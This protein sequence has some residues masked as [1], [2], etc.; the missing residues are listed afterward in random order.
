MNKLHVIQRVTT[1]FLI[2]SILILMI[3]P[4]QA[5]SKPDLLFSEGWEHWSISRTCENGVASYEMTCP[6]INATIDLLQ[7]NTLEIMAYCMAKNPEMPSRINIIFPYENK[8][9]VEVTGLASVAFSATTG[10]RALT[11][12]FLNLA[13]VKY[14]S[15]ST[16]SVV[17]V[18]DVNNPNTASIYAPEVSFGAEPLAIAR[19]IAKDIQAETKIT[20]E[21]IVLLNDYIIKH[22]E[23]NHAHLE[24]GGRAY[25]SLGALV[26]GKA[27]CSGYVNVVSDVCYL[28]NIP[29]YQM[30]DSKNNHAWNVVKIDGEWLMLDTTFNDTGLKAKGYYLADDFNDESHFYT[31]SQRPMLEKHVDALRRAEDAADKFR[32]LGLI[33]GDGNSFALA[34]ALTYEALAVILSRLDG[35]EKYIVGNAARLT[36]IGATSGCAAWA[37]PYVGYCVEKQYYGPRFISGAGMSMTVTYTQEILCDYF[38]VALP[39][40]LDNVK[41]VIYSGEWTDNGAIFLRG[42]FFEMLGR[43]I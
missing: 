2:L 13:R 3:I 39:G 6:D 10:L 30:T 33:Q 19:Q 43:C 41:A 37:A 20:R 29:C 32:A 8:S 40:K 31:Q 17:L 15:G 1:A 42:D 35:A 5:S 4:A 11:N 9:Q 27:V 16:P 14:R 26:D 38:A 24:S 28:L 36:S 34:D 22:V 12:T 18:L 7:K 25:S 21:Q 23:Y